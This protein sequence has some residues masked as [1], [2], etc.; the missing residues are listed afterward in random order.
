MTA[1]VDGV[2]AAAP[3]P[4]EDRADA[5]GYPAGAIPV[6]GYAA[7]GAAAIVADEEE[8]M[9]TAGEPVA[10]PAAARLA[11]EGGVAISM[12]VPATAFGSAC[13]EGSAGAADRATK[14]DSCGAASCFHHAQR[15]PDWQPT[16]PATTANAINVWTID[17]LMTL[18][19]SAQ[20][21]CE[22]ARHTAR[23]SSG[24][25]RPSRPG[26]SNHRGRI[27]ADESAMVLL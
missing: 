18:L 10:A 21:G 17:R 4:G 27:V 13:D 26:G 7:D 8:G 24:V 5:V 9:A 22:A 23:R 11:E 20:N 3:L 2:A 25:R 6:L 15:G 19:T 14:D 16:V 12:P 1:A